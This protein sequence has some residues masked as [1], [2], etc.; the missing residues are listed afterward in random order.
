[1]NTLLDYS[2][3]KDIKARKNLRGDQD[4]FSSKCSVARP[5]VSSGVGLS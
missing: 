5:W 1:M 4:H 2:K 3:I